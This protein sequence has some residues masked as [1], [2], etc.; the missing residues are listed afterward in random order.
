MKSSVKIERTVLTTN[1]TNGHEYNNVNYD[2]LRY[3]RIAKWPLWVK[4]GIGH[5]RHTA[6]P[7]S[8]KHY[9]ASFSN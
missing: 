2:C 6:A 1:Y 5:R 4:I 7:R 8:R 3:F 9:R